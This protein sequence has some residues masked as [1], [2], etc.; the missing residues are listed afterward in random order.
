MNTLKVIAVISLRG[1]AVPLAP[2]VPVA[3][4]LII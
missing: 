2:S 3:E 4:D 1:A